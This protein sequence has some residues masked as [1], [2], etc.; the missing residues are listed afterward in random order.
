MPFCRCR[1][2]GNRRRADRA[3]AA[4]AAAAPSSDP[5]EPIPGI[6]MKGKIGVGGT[7]TIF[8]IGVYLVVLGG[9][10]C[11]VFRLYEEVAQ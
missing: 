7:A 1:G 2:G 5:R 6:R 11:L 8:D 3:G 9:V 4:P 10:L